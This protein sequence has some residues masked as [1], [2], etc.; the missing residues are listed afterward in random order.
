MLTKCP[1]CGD[2]H[3]ATN[4]DAHSPRE[5]DHC[6]S[7]ECYCRYCN[8]EVCDTKQCDIAKTHAGGEE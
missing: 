8:N 6:C 5:R 3:R 1:V 2:L 4:E 7:R